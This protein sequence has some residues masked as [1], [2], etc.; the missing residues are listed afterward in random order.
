LVTKFLINSHFNYHIMKGNVLLPKI[1]VRKLTPATPAGYIV[2]RKKDLYT[3][4]SAKI[5][6]IDELRQKS[7]GKKLHLEVCFYL[8]AETGVE[9]DIQKDLDNLLKVVFDV[10]P[11]HFTDENNEPTEGLGLIEDKSDYMIFEINA[12]KKF[13]K[14]HDDEGYDIEISEFVEN[15]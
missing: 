4:I 15:S 1:K 13:V 14:T 2:E 8:N 11:Q 10:L 5:P 9:G 7:L 12:S 6:N 3:A